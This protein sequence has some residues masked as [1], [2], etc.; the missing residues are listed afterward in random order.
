MNHQ[1]GLI[2]GVGRRWAPVEAACD[3]GFVVDH[4]EFVVQLVATGKASGADPLLLQ[5]F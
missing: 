1:Q 3:H 4:G 2:G 5:W